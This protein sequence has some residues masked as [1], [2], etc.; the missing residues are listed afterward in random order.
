MTVDTAD[1]A[2][3]R[4]APISFSQLRKSG[5]DIWIRNMTD[6]PISI[7]DHRRDSQFDL[8]LERAG[9]DGDIQELPK[10]ALRLP[11]LRRM[12]VRGDV[13]ISTDE[14][15]EEQVD[16]QAALGLDSERARQAAI[17]SKIEASNAVRD[18][19]PRNCLE[20]GCVCMQ[21]AQQVKRGEPPLC[22]NH[23][24]AA[25]L[26]ITSTQMGPEGEEIFAWS[27]PGMTAPQPGVKPVERQ[28][29]RRQRDM[30]FDEQ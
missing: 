13:I 7:R 8:L 14:T 9:D 11:G 26:Y 30:N 3:N 29:I 18:M 15:M 17:L 5:E 10:E 24:H 21:N 23:K 20:C 12:M 1:A 25:G 6:K 27:K 28:G 16:L 22:D 19:L 4:P 2:D